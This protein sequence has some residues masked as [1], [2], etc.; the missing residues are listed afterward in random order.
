MRVDKVTTGRVRREAIEAIRRIAV[1]FPPDFKFNR[2]EIHNRFDRSVLGC[3][4]ETRT[5]QER[6]TPRI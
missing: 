3:E 6:E 5:R 1:P 2:E 4:L